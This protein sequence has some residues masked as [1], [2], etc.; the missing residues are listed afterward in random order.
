MNTLNLGIRAHDLGQRDLQ[1]LC[2]QLKS[3]QFSNI[4]LAIKKSFPELVPSFQSLSPGI[5]SFFGDYFARNGIKISTL[6]CY[7]NISSKDISVRKEALENF[8]T[9]LQL[10]RDFRASIVGTETG[11]VGNGYTLENFTEEAY[12]IARSSVIEMVEYA[13]HFGA[14]VGIEAG[15]NHPLYSAKLARRLVE[16]VQSPHLKIILDVANLINLENISKR[17]KIL[18]EAIDL[19]HDDIAMIHLKDFTVHNGKLEIVPVGKGMLNFE[20]IL[21]YLKRDR[22]FLHATLEE[23]KGESIKPAI[24]YIQEIY[25]RL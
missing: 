4:Q 11:S 13:E 10:A 18:A 1:E 25:H 24:D 19:L 21:S 16:E 3:Y 7:V 14:T 17:D 22:P 5:A 2:E 23:T 12:Q 15:L 8:K 9:H 20:P 6:G